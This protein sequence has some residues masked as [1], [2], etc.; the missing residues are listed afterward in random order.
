VLPGE[1]LVLPDG[2]LLHIQPKQ[3]IY[4]IAAVEYRRDMARIQ[5]LEGQIHNIASTLSANTAD[6]EKQTETIQSKLQD[7]E[8]LAVTPLAQKK[9]QNLRSELAAKGL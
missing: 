7:I 3:Y 5:I 4:D 9:L 6:I 8:R 2:R 1:Q